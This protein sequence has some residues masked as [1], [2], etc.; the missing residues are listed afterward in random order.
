MGA[1]YY[2]LIKYFDW[3]FSNE[4]YAKIMD[5]CPYPCVVF[6]HSTPLLRKL[7]DVEMYLQYNKIVNLKLAVNKLNGVIIR[8]GETFSYWKLI[9]KPTY[10]KG[11]LDGLVLC[12]NGTFKPG[13]GGGFANFQT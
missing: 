5:Y 6:T 3:Y 1:K 12:P 13:V 7:K 9:G 4:K 11:Y 8:P 2:T 10:K